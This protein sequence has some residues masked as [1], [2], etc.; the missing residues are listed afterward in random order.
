MAA[1]KEGDYEGEYLFNP[2]DSADTRSGIRGEVRKILKQPGY[3]D[4]SAGPVLVR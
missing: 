4:G 3:D 2:I 1:V